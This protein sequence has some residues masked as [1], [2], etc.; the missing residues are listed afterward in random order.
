MPNRRADEGMRRR[1]EIAS[2]YEKALAGLTFLK[3]QSGFIEGH[4]YHLYI[5]EVKDRDG[6]Y[7]FLRE[8]EI[9]SQ[10]HYIPAHLMPYY[11]QFGW[12]E[13]DMP[14][15]EKYYCQGLSLPMY[16]TLTNEEQQFVIEKIIS[17]Y[18]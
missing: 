7:L 1:K 5:I 11:R 9:Y 6:L 14:V 12:K 2:V 4:A 8:N 18:Q 16:P 17:F 10:I 3:R 15:A 13:G